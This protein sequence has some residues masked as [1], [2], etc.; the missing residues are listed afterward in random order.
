[1][2]NLPHKY[3]QFHWQFRF[4]KSAQACVD[5]PLCAKNLYTDLV[6]YCPDFS[7]H[8]RT[9]S[10]S[11]PSLCVS[12]LFNILSI[13][14]ESLM[15][16][17]LKCL[18]I[19]HYRKCLLPYFSGQQDTFPACLCRF[20][21][22]YSKRIAVYSSIWNRFLSFATRRHAQ[23]V[24]SDGSGYSY[25]RRRCKKRM[26]SLLLMACFVST[27]LCCPPIRSSERIHVE[28]SIKCSTS[29]VFASRTTQSR[30]NGE[31]RWRQRRR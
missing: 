24:T 28:A 21:L 29:S 13:H 7:R 15:G 18:R 11:I 25:S 4:P 2:K 10:R 30:S 20:G 6:E 12:T 3:F 1:M 19:F 27:L 14:L 23:E 5:Y 22:R 8:Q 17:S 31:R 26:D 16:F 9:L